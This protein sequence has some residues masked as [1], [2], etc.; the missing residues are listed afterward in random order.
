MHNLWLQVAVTM[1]LVGVAAFAWLW[2]GLFRTA[3]WRLRAD[4][5][6]R[7]ADRFGLALRLG[8]VAALCGFFVAGLF[9]WNF[10]DEE[11]MD[12]LFTLVGMAFG[13]SVWARSSERNEWREE[14][15]SS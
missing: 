13:A 1:G 11:L 15:R 6:D 8:A 10:G 14:P 2:V 4:L 12:F 5:R 9:E 7:T 3:A